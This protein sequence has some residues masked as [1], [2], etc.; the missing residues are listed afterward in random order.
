[1]VEVWIQT[2]SFADNLPLSQ[3]V[4]MGEDGTVLVGFVTYG[5]LVLGGLK[6]R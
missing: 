3:S 6:M 4:G 1:M 2:T 5:A